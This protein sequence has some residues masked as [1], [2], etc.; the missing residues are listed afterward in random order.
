MADRAE[1]LQ[2]RSLDSADLR[3]VLVPPQDLAVRLYY[4]KGGGEGRGQLVRDIAKA[5]DPT[6]LPAL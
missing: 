5:S 2:S 4:T 6:T 3:E 1:E